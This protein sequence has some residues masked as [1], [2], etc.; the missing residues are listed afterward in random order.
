MAD[1]YAK[2]DEIAKKTACKD[3][4]NEDMDVGYMFE[5]SG[6]ISRRIPGGFIGHG[7]GVLIYCKACGKVAKTYVVTK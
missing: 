3:C 1:K 2:F 4:G 6:A 5:G 7:N